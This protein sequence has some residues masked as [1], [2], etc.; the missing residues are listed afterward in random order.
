[1]GT[2]QWTAAV[3]LGLVFAPAAIGVYLTFRVLD[4]PDLTVDASFPAGGAIAAT[5]IVHG[6]S[7][8]LTV[9]AAA[10]VGAALGIVTALLSVFLRVNSLLASIITL[11]AAFTVNLRIQGSS[12]ISLIGT[13]RIYTPFTDPVRDLLVGWFGD[14]GAQIHRSVVTGLVTLVVVALLIAALWWFFR[15]E[16]GLAMRA[17][18]A[19]VEMSRSQ[20]I[21]TSGYLIGGVAL[22]N[23]LTAITGAFFVQHEGFADVN[24]GSGLIVAGLAAVI[25]GEVLFGRGSRSMVWL[26]IAAALGMVV[27][28]IAIAIALNTTLRLPAS[29]PIKLEATDIKLA[30]AAVV[31][32]MLAIPRIRAARDE[33]RRRRAR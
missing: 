9:P 31:G 27:Y 29:E 1:M 28:R 7:P 32:A 11:T 4:F 10:L 25:I 23:A 8:W 12:N 24:S 3:A 16:I 6:A 14:L 33:R 22:S 21:N 2:S 5:L 26:I 17:T 20:A 19:N 18:G 15:T 30:T 13:D